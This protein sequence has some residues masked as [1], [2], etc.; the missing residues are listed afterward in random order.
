VKL[1]CGFFHLLHDFRTVPEHRGGVPSLVPERCR[2]DNS[3]HERRIPQCRSIAITPTR[4]ARG[5]GT[6]GYSSAGTHSR[7][8]ARGKAFRAGLGIPPPGEAGY[9]LGIW[10][11]HRLERAE[12]SA[13]ILRSGNPGRRCPQR[14]CS[15]ALEGLCGTL[16][17]TVKLNISFY[18]YVV[19]SKRH[20]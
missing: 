20:F 7:R 16:L 4:A 12:H 17:N 6:P 10:S 15:Q 9:T 11:A 2:K 3:T 18:F 1:S 8:E 19:P 13:S 14:A 5:A